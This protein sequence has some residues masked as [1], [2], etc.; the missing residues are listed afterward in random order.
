MRQRAPE[1]LVLAMDIGSSSTRSAFF[2][3]KGRV[4]PITRASREYAVHYSADG[5]AELS[6]ALLRNAVQTCARETL[7]ARRDAS[8]L[9]DVP[10]VAA[11]GSAFWH[12]LL[13]L[14]QKGRP[15]TPVFTWADSRCA[16]DAAQLRI[17]LDER[18]IHARTG[19]MLR[20]SFWPAKL[21]WLRRTRPR[22]FHRVARW[23]SPAEW[24]YEELFGAGGCNPSMA[25][26]TGLYDLRGHW[27]GAL[28]A[29]GGIDLSQ[30]GALSEVADAREP[31]FPELRD[32]NVFTAIG[33]GAAGNLGCGAD[34]AGR[35]AINIGTSAAVRLVCR[36][37]RVTSTPFGLFR[38]VVDHDR[39]VLG[40]AVSNAGNLRK[41]CLRELRVDDTSLDKKKAF[42]RSAAANDKITVL[43]FW[44]SERAPTWPEN[45][46]GAIVGLSQ[47][48]SA[49]EILR[50]TTCA[51]YY[52]LAEIL[53]LIERA[54][55]SAKAVIVSGGILHSTPSLRLLADALGR[56]LLISPEAEA[57]LRGAAVY[58]LE[59]LGQKRSPLRKAEIVRH[60]RSLAKKHR[61]RRKQQIALEKTLSR[62]LLPRS[63]SRPA[64]NES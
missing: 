39:T 26:G 32:L 50:V 19:C 38:Y 9:R 61:L 40:G 20:A 2:D 6:P 14:D 11:G 27:D 33:D 64:G 5:G 47:A 53:G 18:K 3:E 41:W 15:I 23:V 8:S 44:V 52:R 48:S 63:R 49:A 13:G 36:E 24:I 35:I 58:V 12:S 54:T 16:T 31:V 60:E 57:S 1:F 45:L 43:P 22:L 56:D 42:S 17:E 28:C 37:N 55:R 25:S 34:T 62:P 59:K 30:L 21:R 7:R 4:L 10:I 51:V 29:A 46:H